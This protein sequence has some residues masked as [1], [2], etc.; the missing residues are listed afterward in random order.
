MQKKQ[1][2]R[3]GYCT[4]F[5]SFMFIIDSSKLSGSSM[6]RSKSSSSGVKACVLLCRLN[7][8]ALIVFM[9]C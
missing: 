8:P 7:V 6:S 9:K 2:V 4:C 1:K 5:D 3:G